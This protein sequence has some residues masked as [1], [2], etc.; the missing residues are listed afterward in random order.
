MNFLKRIQLSKIALHWGLV[1]ILCALISAGCDKSSNPSNPT[2]NPNQKTQGTNPQVASQK[3]EAELKTFC[4]SHHLFPKPD[5]LPRWAWKKE[6]TKMYDL[7][8]T[9]GFEEGLPDQAQ[10]LA[11]FQTRAPE[12]LERPK[13]QFQLGPGKLDKLNKLYV[14]SGSWTPDPAVSHISFHKLLTPTKGYDLIACDMRHGKIFAQP[15][16]TQRTT[17]LTLA[18]VP[19][20]ARVEVIDFDKDGRLDLL[21]SDLGSFLPGDHDKGQALWLQR[22]PE[23]KFKT[24]VLLNKVGRVADVQAADVDGDGD[25]DLSV[26]EF[27]WRMGGRVLF[28]R[29]E[30]FKADGSPELKLE[31]LD[32]RPGAIRVPFVDINGDGKLDIVTV[33]S[34]HHERVVAYLQNESGQFQLK[35]LYVAPHPEWGYTGI[36]VVDLDRDGDIDILLT[37]GDTLDTSVL[38]PYQGIQFLENLGDLKFKE[39]PQQQLPGAHGLEVIDVDGD[40]DLDVIASAFLPQFPVERARK[41]LNLE[42]L[43]WLEQTEPWKFNRFSLETINCDHPTIAALDYDNDGD[44]DIVSGN[45]ALKPEVLGGI[46]AYWVLY[47]NEAKK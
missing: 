9:M 43:I 3:F 19:H 16:Y 18:R 28:L 41:P 40:N 27:G 23:G 45:Y 47:K 38:K 15:L 30:G 13:S 10:A 20:P 4:T 33:L 22:T 24:H 11:Y 17:I 31:V 1:C 37:N 39:H 6:I 34:Q 42:S 35:E 8:K 5:V 36:E 44:I 7:V 46:S 12:Q 29:N 25:L 26:A 32:P 21:V 14:K 2:P